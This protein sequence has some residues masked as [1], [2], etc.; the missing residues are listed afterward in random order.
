MR[1][2]AKSRHRK[3]RELSAKK[4]AQKESE[5]NKKLKQGECVISEEPAKEVCEGNKKSREQSSMSRLNVCCVFFRRFVRSFVAE[6]HTNTE[7][8]AC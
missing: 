2:D 3:E 5:N 1:G 4:K 6:S 8:T 7:L